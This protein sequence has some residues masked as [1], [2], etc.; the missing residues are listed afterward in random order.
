MEGV[1][2]VSI[3]AGGALVRGLEGT[4]GGL[5]SQQRRSWGALVHAL[6]HRRRRRYVVRARL[7][8][9]GGSLLAGSDCDDGIAKKDCS[10]RRR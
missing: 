10:P 9:L 6:T 4:I 1:D 3:S 7:I 8:V 5:S 2:L